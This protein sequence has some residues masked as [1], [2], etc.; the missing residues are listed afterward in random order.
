MKADNKSDDNHA[1]MTTIGVA[2]T[3]RVATVIR[4]VA[5]MRGDDN[6]SRGSDA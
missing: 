1:F 4:V 5:T 6:K 3:M 2:A